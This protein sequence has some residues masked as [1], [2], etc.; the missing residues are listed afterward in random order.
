MSLGFGLRHQL[1]RSHP[2]SEID[3]FYGSLSHRARLRLFAA[4]F[5]LFAPVGLLASS[6]FGDGRPPWLLAAHLV[7]SG[8]SAAGWAATF[9]YNYRLVFVVLPMHVAAFWVLERVDHH[10]PGPLG[11]VLITL[12]AAGYILFIRLLGGEGVAKLK[13][14]TEMTLAQRIH[15]DL[16]PAIAQ[17]GPRFEIA[18]RSRP[19][20]AM[21]GDLLDVVERD[22]VTVLCVADVAGHGVPAGVVLAM[23]KAAFRTRLQSGDLG[24]TLL[25][26]MDRVLQGML[27][28]G[29]FVTCLAVRLEA[30]TT[31]YVNAGHLPLLRY[32]AGSGTL[33]RL[34]ESGLPLGAGVTPREAGALQYPWRPFPFRRGDLLLLVTDGFT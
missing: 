34:G 3:R 6:R 1:S 29:M 31:S 10:P 2:A 25:S 9:I 26:D 19:S 13:L 11:L 5:C 7:V 4:I 21:G 22:G 24:T 33:E 23:V 28:P 20:S 32:D 8:L 27:R 12:I 14:Q 16:V 17:E 18:G 30:S 15:R